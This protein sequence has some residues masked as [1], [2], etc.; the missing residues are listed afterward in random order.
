M[1]ARY[2]YSNSHPGK[3]T[4]VCT[5]GCCRAKVE[6]GGHVPE[7]IVL[8]PGWSPWYGGKILCPEHYIV[9]KGMTSKDLYTAAKEA[10]RT[11]ESGATRSSD[12]GRPDYDGYLSPLVIERFGEYMTKHRKQAD[13]TLRDSDNWQKGMPLSTYVKG[14]YRHFMHFWARHRG[15]P[16][17]DKQAA[18]TIE[19]DLCAMLFN[20]QGY[21]HTLLAA[22]VVQK[23]EWA[24]TKTFPAARA[25]T[26]PIFFGWDLAMSQPVMNR[27]KGD[28]CRRKR[29]SLTNR[30]WRRQEKDVADYTGKT[31]TLYGRRQTDTTSYTKLP[32]D[33][34]VGATDRR[35]KNVKSE[36]S[37]GYFTAHGLSRCNKAGFSYGPDRDWDSA[38]RRKG[39]VHYEQHPKV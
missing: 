14:L 16:V 2:D 20:V 10:V 15:W 8:A 6:A 23:D 1:S 9:E 38:G 32:K 30:L 13:G 26:K 27:R 34:R 25:M 18:P 11:F 35:T 39:D 5:A 7:G 19:D 24:S 4:Y 22:K 17:S 21:L 31:V 28:V 36:A 33:L 12:E 29:G 37:T 3:T